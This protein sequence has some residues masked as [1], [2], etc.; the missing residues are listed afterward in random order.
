MGVKMCIVG[1]A[2]RLRLFEDIFRK[3]DKEELTLEALRNDSS[4]FVEEINVDLKKLQDNAVEDLKHVSYSDILPGAIIRNSKNNNVEKFIRNLIKPINFSKNDFIY[5]GCLAFTKGHV[6]DKERWNE[7]CSDI[8]FAVYHG[9]KDLTPVDSLIPYSLRPTNLTKLEDGEKEFP[10]FIKLL[11]VFSHN[12]KIKG[13]F[14]SREEWIHIFNKQSSLKFLKQ[15]RNLEYQDKIDN[16]NI[17]YI[18]E[19]EDINP[20]LEE[21]L[22]SLSKNKSQIAI[23]VRSDNLS[24]KVFDYFKGKSIRELFVHCDLEF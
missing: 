14:Y 7:I 24:K 11:F 20:E 13:Y 19:I 17:F 5:Q 1:C 2:P 22:I 16:V 15:H 8:D 9:R 12:S 21:K 6:K 10:D 3:L 4:F 23:L 18:S